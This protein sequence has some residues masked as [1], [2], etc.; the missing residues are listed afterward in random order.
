MGTC[1]VCKELPASLGESFCDICMKD[2]LA[3]D[4]ERVELSSEALKAV[5]PQEVVFPVSR[6]DGSPLGF[7]HLKRAV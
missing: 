1:I 2:M 7:L 5:E 6:K 3:H 4:A